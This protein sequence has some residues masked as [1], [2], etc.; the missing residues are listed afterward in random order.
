MNKTPKKRV[1]I[2]FLSL[3]LALSFGVP[4]FADSGGI[5]L[6]EDRVI[7]VFASK[8]VGGGTWEYG[9]KTS[10]ILKWKRKKV[11]SNY[12]HP[13]KTHGS[14]AQLGAKT[15]NRSCVK[16]DKTSYASQ[17]SKNTNLTGY[18]YWNTNC[19]L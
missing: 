4:V 15:P 3:V 19:K 12:W 1:L 8:K 10:G 18:A 7:T 9:T 13:N 6:K 17:K 2:T 16:K 11:W 14:S 5:E